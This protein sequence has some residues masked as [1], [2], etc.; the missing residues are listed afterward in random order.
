MLLV[1][2]DYEMITMRSEMLTETMYT[3]WC[4]RDWRVTDRSSAMPASGSAMGQPASQ[5]YGNASRSRT[6]QPAIHQPTGVKS[7]RQ[8]AADRQ[9][10]DGKGAATAGMQHL[11]R[12]ANLVRQRSPLCADEIQGKSFC[13]GPEWQGG[14]AFHRLYITM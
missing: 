10:E 8:R 4:H 1:S 3:T 14:K 6:C 7:R 13:L 9:K 5:P 2:S 11:D 12:P